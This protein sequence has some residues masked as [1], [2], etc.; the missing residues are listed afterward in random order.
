MTTTAKAGRERRLFTD[1]DDVRGKED[2]EREREKERRFEKSLEH[3]RTKSE[4]RARLDS[5]A[6]R[7]LKKREEKPLSEEKPKRNKNKSTILD[8]NKTEI[9]LK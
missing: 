6:L 1:Y 4:P 2:R 8:R 7:R 3:V 9:D 5:D